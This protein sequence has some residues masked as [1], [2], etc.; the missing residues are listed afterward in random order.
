MTINELISEVAT[1][2]YK[3]TDRNA[4]ILRGI[5]KCKNDCAEARLFWK[6][7][8]A[9]PFVEDQVEYDLPADFLYPDMLRVIISTNH[10]YDLV[11]GF[12]NRILDHPFRGYP[13]TYFIYQD[14]ATRKILIGYPNP[15]GAYTF[16]PYY[17]YRP[18]DYTVAANGTETPIMSR[19]FNDELILDCAEA[20]VWH[21]VEAY[22]RG[23]IANARYLEKL[24]AAKSQKLNMNLPIA[25]PTRV[26]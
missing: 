3:D 12:R 13:S 10:Y 2:R 11:P 20:Y 23:R 25:Q 9:I 19:L 16:K 26:F 1:N 6:E 14:G 7:G 21:E 18:V 24:G 5:N 15:S 22:D 8:D 4:S 17:F